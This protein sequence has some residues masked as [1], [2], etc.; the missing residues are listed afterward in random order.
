MCLR[1]L[2]MGKHTR[3]PASQS[4]RVFMKLNT[5]LDRVRVKI[6][7]K[8]MTVLKELPVFQAETFASQTCTIRVL[9]IVV[10]SLN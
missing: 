9:N 4:A 5:S 8:V 1:A 3:Q 7:A 2:G 6:H 10:V